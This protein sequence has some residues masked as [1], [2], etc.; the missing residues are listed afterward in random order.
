METASRSRWL[1]LAGVCLGVF[2]FTLDA[3]IVNIAVPTLVREFN[4]S[5]SAVQWVIQAYL[6][7]V[8]AMILP[9]AHFST[10]IG[11]KRLFLSGILLFT[12]GSLLCGT[13]NSVEMLVVFRVVQAV[14]AASLAALMSSI[15]NTT[16]PPEWL[17][18]ALGIVTATATL[19]TSLGPT[20]GGFLIA[21]G[22]WHWIFLVNVPVG[23]AAFALVLVSLPDTTKPPAAAS[24]R[25][26]LDLFQNGV[27]RDGLA[28][29]A[30]SM[31]ANGAFL[32]LAPL[33]LELTLGYPT[34]KA[35]LLLAASPVMTGITSPIFGIVADRFGRPPVFLAGLVLMTAGMLVMHAFTVTMGEG[36]FLLRVA[37]WGIGMGMFNAPNAAMVMASAP[38]H[39]SDAASALLS[40]AI[41]VG[42]LAGVA[43]GGAM[44]HFFLF[45]THASQ[46]LKNLPPAS[47]AEAVANTL[48]VF[49]LP[50]LFLLISNLSR[51]HRAARSAT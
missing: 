49:A 19:G 34:A 50:L 22:S 17:A 32:F 30:V 51:L 23:T 25:S 12:L 4:T 7:V 14:G 26:Y 8:V 41:M 10:R 44:F 3:S 38:K 33:I 24:W 28:G 36:G 11:Q 37:L 16:F 15:V 20:I 42:Q 9:F 40:M 21:A 2:M 18:Q 45:G 5:L 46:P 29:R 35:G 27:L 47:L 6:A 13:A 43:L 48:P 1:A 39:L 31:M